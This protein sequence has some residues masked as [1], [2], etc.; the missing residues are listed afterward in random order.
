MKILG[1][2]ILIMLFFFNTG[3]PSDKSSIELKFLFEFGA[4]GDAPGEFNHPLG[5]TAGTTNAVYVADS[6][7]NRIQKFDRYGKLLTFIGGA[8]WG[9]GQFQ[10]PMDISTLNGLAIFVADYQNDRIEQYDKDLNYLA[11]IRS[12]LDTEDDKR[13]SLPLSISHSIH[14]EVFILDGESKRLLKMNANFEP[15]LIFGDYDWGEG[16]LVDPQQ[17]IVS[18]FERVYVSDSAKGCVVVYDYFGNFIENIGNDVLEKP[19]GLA[20]YSKWFLFVTDRQTDFK[21]GG[22]GSKA[23]AFNHIGD[24]TILNDWL[25]VTDTD[26]HRIQV[27]EIK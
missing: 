9:Q 5:I 16:E 2:T 12:S 27:F 17:C 11:T 3:L 19:F 14:G 25:F 10:L 21:M 7:N 4:P 22:N 18:K 6:D 13:F 23:G 26:N 15:E 24:L 20:F 8:G 1:M